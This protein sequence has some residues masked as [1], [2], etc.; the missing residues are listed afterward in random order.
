MLLSGCAAAASGGTALRPAAAAEAAQDGGLDQRVMALHATA[1]WDRPAVD[2]T[3][4]PT[5]AT[6]AAAP[7]PSAPRVPAAVKPVAAPVPAGPR[8]DWVEVPS[9]G[10]SVAVSIYSDCTGQTPLTRATAA[11]DTCVPA[12]EVFL[13]GHRPGVFAALPG[14]ITG[15]LVD[16]WD[17]AGVLH[18]YR[19]YQVSMVPKADGGN[20]MTNQH[21]ALLMQTCDDATGSY[22]YFYGA[23]V[24]A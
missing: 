3:P 14:A 6:P 10:I 13:V 21:P 4:T 24:G 5:P 17:S 11:R 7:V 15:A 9:V 16:Y 22:Y 19:V 20:V 18:A 23:P 8:H 1:S 12:S 2:P